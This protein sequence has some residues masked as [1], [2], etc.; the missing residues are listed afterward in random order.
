VGPL[1]RR[2]D[3]IV[4]RGEQSLERWIATGRTNEP[5]SRELAK[6]TYAEI[7][8][9]FIDQLAENPELQEL[10][11]T[12]GIGLASQAR[13]EVRERTVTADNLMEGLVRRILRRTPRSELPGPPPEVQK[14][15]N[16][17]LDEY[18]TESKSEADD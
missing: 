15:A 10:V 7:V 13:D 11:T 1:Q 8:D 3:R 5:R 14:W 9:E 18:K 16:L 6:M 17:T 2:Y 12:Q 4:R